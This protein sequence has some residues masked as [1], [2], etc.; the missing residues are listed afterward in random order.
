MAEKLE[1]QTGTCGC[2]LNQSRYVGKDELPEIKSH[3]P[4]IRNPCCK[5]VSAN[6]GIGRREA[7]EQTRFPCIWPADKTDIC[8]QAKLHVKLTLYPTLSRLGETG[9]LPSRGGKVHVALAASAAGQQDRLF[10][11]RYSFKQGLTGR[12]IGNHGPWRDLDDGVP[13]V[14]A[15]LLPTASGPAGLRFHDTLLSQVDKGT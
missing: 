6:F 1:T 2:P 14:S 5:R 11:F 3:Y 15:V 13:S 8:D 12:S 7:P 9:G 4:K 10:T